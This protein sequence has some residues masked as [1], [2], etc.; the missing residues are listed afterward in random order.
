VSAVPGIDQFRAA[1]LQHLG[2]LKNLGFSVS[3]ESRD[4]IRFE[5]S[6]VSVTATVSSRGEVELRVAELGNES[7]LGVLTLAGMVGRADAPRVV[8]LLTNELQSHDAALGGDARY[9]QTLTAEQKKQSQALTEWAS[10]HGPRP[11]AG[12]PP[13]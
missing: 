11:S 5:S 3:D 4:L 2:F 6:K 12:K 8:E 13:Q 1:A 7:G 9:F 10:G